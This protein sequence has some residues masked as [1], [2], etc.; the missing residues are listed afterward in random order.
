MART[1]AHPVAEPVAA[2]SLADYL[3]RIELKAQPLPVC[4]VT[5]PDAVDGAIH[6]GTFA[7]IR[8]VRGEHI[9][10]LLSDGTTI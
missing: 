7:G 1:K 2:E 8:L 3:A 10:A 6:Q 4:Q 5:H 9:A